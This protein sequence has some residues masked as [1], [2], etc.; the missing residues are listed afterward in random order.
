MP[1]FP[2]SYNYARGIVGF[3][4]GRF[5]VFKA[6]L[7]YALNAASC[8]SDSGSPGDGFARSPSDALSGQERLL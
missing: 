7:G 2:H 6:A 1:L 4:G 3:C 5:E 8:V